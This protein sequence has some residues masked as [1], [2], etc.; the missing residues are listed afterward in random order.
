MK[1][2]DFEKHLASELE[3]AEAPVQMDSLLSA[4]NLSDKPKRRPFGVFIIIPMFLLLGGLA[5]LALSGSFSSTNDQNS[6]QQY[7][8]SQSGIS[9]S[10]IQSY[11]DQT[12]IQESDEV[13]AAMSTSSSDSEFNGK[14]N[15]NSRINNNQQKDNNQEKINQ[16][17]QQQES[18][19]RSQINN[20][21]N[22]NNSQKL[23]SEL[24]SAVNNKTF[25][26]RNQNSISTN[27]NVLKEGR[28]NLETARASSSL[29]PGFEAYAPSNRQSIN[30]PEAASTN[31]NSSEISIRESNSLGNKLELDPLKNR[32]SLLTIDELEN[33]NDDLF[34]R[35]KINCPSF[36]QAHWRLALIPEVGILAPIKTLALKSG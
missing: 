24:T 27:T 29:S 16:V 28:G 14:V 23:S 10:T 5:Y 13:V 35:M 8:D 19:S 33:E 20:R 12:R 4:L 36:N 30:A 2:S 1:Y 3:R 31:D 32:R 6:S 18:L 26:S 11:A 22:R 17:G 21:N 34:S 25:K 9:N 15:Q 7:S